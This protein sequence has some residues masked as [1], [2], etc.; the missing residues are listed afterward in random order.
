MA[1][2]NKTLARRLIEEVWNKGNYG[3]IDELYDP[4]FTSEDPMLG[5]ADLNGFRET[6]K[7]YRTAFPD[8]KVEILS[9]VSEGNFVATRWRCTGT[10]RGPL[11][12]MAPTGKVAV[13]NGVD[14]AEVRNGKIISDYTMFDSLTLLRQLGLDSV[15]VPTPELR[16][17]PG[18]EKRA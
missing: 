13:T 9:L 14:I 1:T 18:V 3:V 10:H 12:G 8:L 5:T 15:A 4:Q 11:L 17:T 6:V 2:D 7:G 16:T